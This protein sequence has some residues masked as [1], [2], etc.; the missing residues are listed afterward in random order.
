MITA[1]DSSVAA[2]TIPSGPAPLRLSDDTLWIDLIDPSDED[3]DRVERATGLIL[4]SAHQLAEIETS[5][6][7][8]IEDGMMMMSTPV[9]YREGDGLHTIP[10]GF[11]L[12]PEVLV[13]IR[14]H[15]LKSFTEYV[16]G[17]QGAPPADR[18]TAGP[19]EQRRAV[20]LG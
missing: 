19:D 16:A 4:P 9:L 6:R 8:V 14:S 2:H 15:T 18:L 17:R 7:L 5:S 11:V 1:Y 13:T 3:D 12:G 20:A 10:V